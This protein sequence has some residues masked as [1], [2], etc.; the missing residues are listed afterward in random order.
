MLGQSFLIALE[1][2]R[3][4]KLR[5]FLTMLGVII[6]VMAVTTIVMVSNGFQTY[7]SREFSSMGTKTIYLMYDP[8]RRHKQTVGAID[9]LTMDDAQYLKDRIPEIDRISP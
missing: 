5:A 1:M 9:G 2:L 3:L 7:M 4:H 6:G 8:G